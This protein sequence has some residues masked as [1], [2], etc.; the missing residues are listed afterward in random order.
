[1]SVK[2]VES[3]KYSRYTLEESPQ[4]S[5]HKADQKPVQRKNMPFMKLFFVVNLAK[6]TSAGLLGLT[7]DM[8]SNRDVAVFEFAFFRSISNMIISAILIKYRLNKPLWG[9]FPREFRGQW[10]S[11]PFVAQLTSCASQLHQS[12]Y[13]SASRLL[14][15]T[16]SCLQFH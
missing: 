9:G 16:A 12:T 5:K 10:Q 2:D 1:M 7:K 6:I 15:L 11:D 8:L 13:L 4:T 3:P 14:S